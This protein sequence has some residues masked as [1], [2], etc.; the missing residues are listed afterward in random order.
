MP[1]NGAVSERHEQDGD[2]LRD[3]G[4]RH[5][6]HLGQ[7]LQERDDDADRHGGADRRAGGDDHRPERRLDDIEGVGLVHAHADRDAGAER[8]LLA[9]VQDRHG[10]VRR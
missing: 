1:M 7:R 9:V 8:K 2:D 3:E 6:L 5:L 10:A 4:Q